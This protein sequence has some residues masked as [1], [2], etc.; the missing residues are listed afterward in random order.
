GGIFPSFPEPEHGKYWNQPYSLE[1]VSESAEAITV[2]M[3]RQDDL[4]LVEGVPEVYGVGR[5]D[6][7]VEVD[8][9]LRAGRSSLEIDTKLTNT[10]N[11]AIAEFEYWTVTTLA[12]GSAPVETAIPL[13]TRI[14]AAM[15]RVHLL[16]S[17][18]S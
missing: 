14:I 6:I 12:P 4:D 18:W 17:S 8:V 16:E 7:L 10:Q 5:T 9:T 2:R 3:S 11:S 1:V 13:N 15:D